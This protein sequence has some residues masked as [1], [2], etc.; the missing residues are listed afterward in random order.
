MIIDIY[1]KILYIKMNLKDNYYCY[2]GG[3]EGQSTVI[4][5]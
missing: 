3:G 5:D 2:V 1:K 4:E